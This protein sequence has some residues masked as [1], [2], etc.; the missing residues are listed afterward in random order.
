MDKPIINEVFADNGQHS[1]WELRDANTGKVLWSE[2]GRPSIT[3]DIMGDRYLKSSITSIHDIE[4]DKTMF[5]NR[6]AGFIVETF[7]RV[8]K[9]YGE[10]IPY[11]ST[12]AEINAIKHGWDLKMKKVIELWQ[13]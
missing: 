6:E 1:H 8:S 13:K 2:K 4:R 5:L 12:P 9:K 3:V 10:R 7:G 11:E